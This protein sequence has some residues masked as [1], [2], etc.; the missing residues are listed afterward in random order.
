MNICILI[1]IYRPD[2]AYEVMKEFV[3]KIIKSHVIDLHALAEELLT[4]KIINGR[5]KRKAIDDNTGHSYDTR[6]RELL[7]IVTNSV[8]AVEGVF[9][10]FLEILLEEN[11]L[12][13]EQFYDNMKSRYKCLS[14]N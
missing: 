12:I 10:K 3:P 9:K 2:L 1:G 14:D 11:T 7:D 13:A 5:Q 6:M 4:R 8:G